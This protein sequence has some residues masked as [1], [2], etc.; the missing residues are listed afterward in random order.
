MGWNANVIAYKYISIRSSLGAEIL[1]WLNIN[2]FQST[3]KK[4]YVIDFLIGL[5]YITKFLNSQDEKK[6]KFFKKLLK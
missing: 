6:I 4:N 1:V 3:T 2:I 5:N